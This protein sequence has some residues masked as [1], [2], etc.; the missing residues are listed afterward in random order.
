MIRRLCFVHFSSLQKVVS[1]AVLC[2]PS[3]QLVAIDDLIHL[4]PINADEGMPE[5]VAYLINIFT[6]VPSNP[7]LHLTLA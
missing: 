5:S 4:S 1:H 2:T 3:P 7:I 6:M